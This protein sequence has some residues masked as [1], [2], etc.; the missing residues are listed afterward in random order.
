MCRN[1]AI[2][3][4]IALLGSCIEVETKANPNYGENGTMAVPLFYDGTNVYAKIGV[5]TPAQESGNT[6]VYLSSWISDL[7]VITLDA[8]KCDKPFYD[9]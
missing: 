6:F 2:L 4:N 7:I 9:Y 3:I 8:L 5:G 1:L